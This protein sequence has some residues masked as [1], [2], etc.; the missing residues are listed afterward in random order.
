MIP[1]KGDRFLS[2]KS[3]AF[4]L[5]NR[6]VWDIIQIIFFVIKKESHSW[7][8]KSWSLLYSVFVVRVLERVEIL[9]HRK[10]MK[11][12]NMPCQGKHEEMGLA[13]ERKRRG[14]KMLARIAKMSE[15]KRALRKWGEHGWKCRSSRARALVGKT[16]VNARGR[17]R[18]SVSLLCR[19]IWKKD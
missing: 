16:T 7:R 10:R 5:L 18:K 14:M 15:N 4:V 1:L 13:A 9:T 8:K 12:A 6:Y 19:G 3:S 17:N 11:I 2:Q